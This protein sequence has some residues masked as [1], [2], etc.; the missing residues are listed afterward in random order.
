MI[1]TALACIAIAVLHLIG[2]E[3]NFAAIWLMLGALNFGLAS[4]RRKSEAVSS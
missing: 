2:G 4:N 1:T 3:E